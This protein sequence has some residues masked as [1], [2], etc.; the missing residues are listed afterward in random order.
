MVVF[1]KKLGPAVK[2]PHVPI[3][4]GICVGGPKPD[5]APARATAY[6]ARL[7]KQPSIQAHSP[8]YGALH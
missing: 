3:T 1:S 4:R 8:T 6:P 7:H 5:R 2:Q